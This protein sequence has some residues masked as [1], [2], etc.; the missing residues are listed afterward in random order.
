MISFNDASA[1]TDAMKLTDFLTA[2]GY[3]TFC[4]KNYCQ[5]NS[6]NWRY[7][8]LQGVNYCKLYIP[9]MTNGW[10]RFNEYQ[11]E[12]EVIK[13]RCADRKITVIPVIYSDFDKKY[14]RDQSHFYLSIW[15]NI[16]SVYKDNDTNWMDTL[17]NLMPADCR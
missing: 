3:D 16:Q 11:F 5:Y 12:T 15:R 8:T 6:G 7:F 4:T 10:Q 2:N 1:G 14:D 9:L 13:N 17:L